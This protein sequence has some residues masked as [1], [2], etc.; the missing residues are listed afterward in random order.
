MKSVTISRS[1]RAGKKY[2]AVFMI[3][4]KKKTTHFGQ[5][6]AEDYTQH[7]DEDRKRRY[8][9]RHR[10][11]ENWNDPTSAGALSRYILWEHKSFRT[12]V[13]SFKRRFRF[14]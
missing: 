7:H 4:G 9:Q 14:V 10:A 1:T 6:G 3:N 8:I 12:A 2:M 13:S 5:S 11:R